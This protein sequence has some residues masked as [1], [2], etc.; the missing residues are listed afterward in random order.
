VGDD[1]RTDLEQEVD[2]QEKRADE[3]RERAEEAASEEG[4]ETPPDEDEQG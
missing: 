1:E 2:E 4:V 3:A